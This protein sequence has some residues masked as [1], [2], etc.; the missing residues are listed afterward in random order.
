MLMLAVVSSAKEITIKFYND[1][2]I[3]E[4]F[5]DK[6]EMYVYTEDGFTL[7]MECA[8]VLRDCAMSFICI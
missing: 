3:D 4:S 6:G 8:A 2:K 5:G 7:L 1:D